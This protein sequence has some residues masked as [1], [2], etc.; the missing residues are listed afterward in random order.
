MCSGRNGCR[1]WYGFSFLWIYYRWWW[2]KLSFLPFVGQ[3]SLCESIPKLESIRHFG[4]SFW[5]DTLSQDVAAKRLPATVGFACSSLQHPKNKQNSCASWFQITMGL[6]F[7]K[8][9]QRMIGKQE[10]GHDI[11]MNYMTSRW[12]L[13][14]HSLKLTA[15]APWKT[16]VPPKGHF[17]TIS[18]WGASWRAV[19]FK[20]GWGIL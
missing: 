9:W 19:S 3:M 13:T 16:G 12:R 11:Y 1:T 14:L 18:F 20:G 6:A 7:T 5:S 8:I 4:V 10:P 15:K 2:M 17:P